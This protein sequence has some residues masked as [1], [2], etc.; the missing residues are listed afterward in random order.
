MVSSPCNC[1]AES[2][3]SLAISTIVDILSLT[4]T[5]TGELYWLPL[6][7]VKLSCKLRAIDWACSTATCRL[8][9]AK[10]KPT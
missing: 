9:G 3:T 10:T 4:N 6:V 8:L 1:T 5:P 2:A 7:V